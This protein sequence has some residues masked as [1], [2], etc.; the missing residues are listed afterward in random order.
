MCPPPPLNKWPTCV[1]TDFNGLTLDRRDKFRVSI[2]LWLCC[3]LSRCVVVCWWDD[4]NEVP[5]GG[6]DYVAVAPPG[7]VDEMMRVR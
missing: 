1:L 7:S 5:P 4:M 3:V 2:Y 6:C